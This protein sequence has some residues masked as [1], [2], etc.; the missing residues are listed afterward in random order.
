MLKHYLSLLCTHP[1]LYRVRS[2][3]MEELQHFKYPGSY[4]AVS[5]LSMMSKKQ[6]DFILLIATQSVGVNLF[7]KS[8]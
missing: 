4:P 1:V 7:S 6:R 5:A 3:A 2:C 8:H